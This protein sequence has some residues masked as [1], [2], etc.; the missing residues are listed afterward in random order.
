MLEEEDNPSDKLV[1]VDEEEGDSITESN[2]DLCP[3]QTKY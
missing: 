2:E 3:S 1:D